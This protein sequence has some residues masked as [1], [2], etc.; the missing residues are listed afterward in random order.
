VSAE[1]ESGGGTAVDAR[2]AFGVQAGSYNT[3]VNYYYS[4]Q[5]WTVKPARPPL[6]GS[7]YRGLSAFESDDAELFFGRDEAAGQVLGRLSRCAGGPGLVVVSGVSGAG[8]SS[9]LRA[10]VLPRL[11]R[12][13]LEGAPGAALWPCLLLTPGAAPLDELA[14]QVA[15]LAGAD[16]AMVARSLAADPAGFALTARQAA[17]ARHDGHPGPGTRRL[18]LVV[19]QFEQLFTA[20]PDE[21]QRRAFITALHAA[22]TTPGQAPAALVVL[23]VRADFEARCA[24]YPELAAAIQ[25]RYLLTAMTGRQLRLAI[26]GP[27]ARAGSSVAADLTEVLVREVSTRL[28][29]GPSGPGGA[30]G[31]GALPLLSHALDQAWRT[32]DGDE[33][34][35]ADYERTGGIESAVAR[36]AQQ[37]YDELTPARQAI[38][39]QVFLRLVAA[40]ADGTDTA[41]PAATASLPGAGDGDAVAVLE[42]FA[43]RRLLTLGAGT[44][45]ITHEVLL[46]AWPL[47]RDGWLAETR[48]DRIIRTGLS[49][50]AAEWARHSRDPAYLYTGS[51]L[52]TAAAAAAR[53]GA[54]PARHPPLTRGENSFL[55]ASDRARRHRARRRQ[56]L[57]AALTALTVALAAITAVAIGQ[58]DIADAERNQAISARDQAASDALAAQSEATGDTDPAL[59]RLEAVAAWHL[60]PTSRAGYAVLEAAVLPATSILASHGTPVASVAFSPDGQTL[61][62]GTSDG[63][64]QLWDASTRESSGTLSDRNGDPVVSLAFSP[65]GKTLA[66]GAST[67]TGNGAGSAVTQLW[68]VSTRQLIATLPA[69]NGAPVVSV[70][71]SP[72]GK[73]LAVGMGNGTGT[74]ASG[75][76][77]W[78]VGTRE[79]S[80]TLPAGNGMEVDAVTF[81]PD[82]R[83]LAVGTTGNT[84]GATELWDAGTRQL[85]ATLPARGDSVESVAFSPDGRTLAAGTAGG[86]IQLWDAGTRQLAATLPA[87][88]DSVE[89]VAFSPS[90]Q[91]LAADTGNSTVQ[92]WDAGARQLIATL[93]AGSG[94]FRAWVAFSP[95][96]QTLAA[97][98][99]NGTIQ[100]T[101]VTAESE[102]TRPLATLTAGTDAAVASMTLSP[103]GRTLAVAADNAGGFVQLQL[104]DVATRRP[105]AALSADKDT[106][107]SSVAFSPDGKTLAVA[108]T[109]AIDNG[110]VQLWDVATRRLSVTLPAGGAVESVAFSP[111]GKTLAAATKGTVQLWDLATGRLSATLPAGNGDVIGSVA[112]SPDGRTLAAAAGVLSADAVNS[113]IQLWDVSTRRRSR[114]PLAVG[115][116]DV[117]G[118]VAFSPDGQTL[119]VAAATGNGVG[120][121]FVQRWNLAT[122]E[123]APTPISTGL[124]LSSVIFSPDG[125]VLAID[126]STG[127]QLWD[128]ATPQQ[129]Q[130]I[131]TLAPDNPPVNSASHTPS[132]ALSP[133][134][135]SHDGMLLVASP[136]SGQV[137][138]WS[139]PYLE[140]AVS[141][142][143]AVTGRPFPADEWPPGIPY[144]KTCP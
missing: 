6:A 42:A 120:S 91:T 18:L 83:V 84:G 109:A 24:D 129:A 143:C 95:D 76:Q 29:G 114:P 70:A 25:G 80:A 48:A 89:S 32:R 60:A 131:S 118:S 2:G 52:E 105:A 98:T 44:V 126:T 78:N 144:Q 46:T 136:G 27:A 55:A 116:G 36:S 19:D 135:L 62:V 22:A 51:L 59:A 92:L 140:D 41:V 39:R 61:A 119:A 38:A 28:P 14:V 94:N 133:M 99:G 134:A 106:A 1:G 81:S 90:G 30:A 107:I 71:F 13:G 26:T 87:R 141:A 115:N 9:L 79:L 142:L 33:L 110:S 117:I 37:A 45:E 130:E 122:G 108:V 112:F 88:G 65:D 75:T 12:E 121:G 66:V 96:G 124:G 68:D 100:L 139:A 11:R 34:T 138:L 10:G 58:R 35:L 137:Q 4:D 40:T 113:T 73:T 97:G 127:T 128:V 56:G 103:D 20:C 15:T 54:D 125:T 85:A 23:G 63:T 5:T 57:L 67:A 69:G 43:A 93:P 77:L 74:G 17:L 102:I 82:G 31:A 49:A 3:Q 47:L 132:S 86:V 111:D 104:W 50:A 8:K 53:A 64:I 101:N 16:A 7:P 21:G 72:D 123:Q